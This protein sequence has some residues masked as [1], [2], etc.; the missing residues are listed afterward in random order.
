M[1]GERLNIG[2]SV[3]KREGKSIERV[4]Q[5]LTDAGW[6]RV[7]SIAGGRVRYYELA[8]INITAIGGPFGTTVIPSGPVRGFAF[9]EDAVKFSRVSAIGAGDN[10]TE[11]EQKSPNPNQLV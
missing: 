4:D 1:V 11:T 2:T 8:G 6:E 5:R 7:D 10:E 3:F 9:G